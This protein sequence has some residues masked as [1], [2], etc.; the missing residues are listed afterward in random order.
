M[1]VPAR[2]QSLP[3]ESGSPSLGPEETPR[4]DFTPY[5]AGAAVQVTASGDP[6]TVYVVKL[7][8][9]GSRPSDQDFKRVG[10]T[11]DHLPAPAGPLSA[12]GREL[13]RDARQH[14]ARHG[15]SAQAPAGQDRFR[16]HRR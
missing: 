1:S 12:R 6:V 7:P 2:S 13:Q 15:P 14:A 8:P 9:H 4:Y 3:F 10:L 16:F 5:G 11:P